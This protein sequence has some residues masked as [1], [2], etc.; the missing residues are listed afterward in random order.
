MQK[1]YSNTK[2]ATQE[3]FAKVPKDLMK[4]VFDGHLSFK[5][6][7]LYTFM[8]YHHKDFWIHQSLLYV[9]GLGK[10]AV[11]EQLQTLV[12]YGMAQFTDHF[13]G[14]NGHYYRAIRKIDCSKIEQYAMSKRHLFGKNPKSPMVLP[15]GMLGKTNRESG[16]NPKSPMVKPTLTKIK[17][18]NKI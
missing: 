2:Q 8:L 3:F 16:K 1:S 17:T 14:K 7:S 10:Y 5:A 4:L 11:K 12:E 13:N 9:D 6:Y 18:K 15:R